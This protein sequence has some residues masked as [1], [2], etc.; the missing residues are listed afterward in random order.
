MVRQ[1]CTAVGP[2]AVTSANRHGHPTPPDAAGVDRE[3]GGAVAVVVDGGVC[4]GVPSTVVRVHADGEI[5]VLRQGGVTV[6]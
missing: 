1:L 4:D 2:L 5:V 6:E 3:L